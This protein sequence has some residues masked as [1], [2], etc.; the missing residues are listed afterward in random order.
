MSVNSKF[1]NVISYIIWIQTHQMYVSISS[2]FLIRIHIEKKERNKSIG[3]WL[4][5]RSLDA[6][7]KCK[8]VVIIL[9]YFKSIKNRVQSIYTKWNERAKIVFWFGWYTHWNIE[10]LTHSGILN[11]CRNC[12]C[13]LCDHFVKWLNDSIQ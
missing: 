13:N 1:Q 4:S 5:A 8:P 7:L 11:E 10:Q 3:H 6:Q 9:D 12:I 2:K